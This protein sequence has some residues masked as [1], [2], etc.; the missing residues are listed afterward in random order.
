VAIDGKGSL[1]DQIKQALF[2]RLLPVYCDDFS[3]VE[4]HTSGRAVNWARLPKN[5]PDKD[6]YLK[7][8]QVECT[9]LEGITYQCVSSGNKGRIELRRDAPDGP[10]MHAI[11]LVKSEEG[12]P[13]NVWDTTASIEGKHNLYVHLINTNAAQ[14]DPEGIIDLREIRLHYKDAH[15]EPVPLKQKREALLA[16]REEAVRTPVMKERTPSNRRTTHVFER[17]NWLAPTE[18]VK[19]RVPEVLGSLKAEGN[20]N[21]QTITT[22]LVSPENPLTARVITNRFWEQL[23]GR[24]I[25]YTMEDFGT[26][27]M[28]PSHPQL[29]DWLAVY[30][31][32]DLQWDMKAL[33]KTIV[34]S[35]TY[36]QGSTINPEGIQHDPENI[37]LSR[38]PRIRLSAEQLRDQ[39]LAVSGLLS[40]KMFGPPVMPPQPEG[41]WQVV[42][43]GEAWKTSEGEDKFRRGIYTHWRRTSP[44]PSMTTFDSPSREFC[45]PRRIPTNT[46]LQ[47][48]V[49]LNDPVFVEAAKALASRMK[50]IHEND[51]RAQIVTGYQIAL[52][53]SPS[54]NTI[55]VLTNLYREAM[56]QIDDTEQE[57]GV[58]PP[59]V[60]NN[61]EYQ[62]TNEASMDGLT[63]V[64]NAI[65]NLDRFIMKE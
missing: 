17:G 56:D 65:L 12:K 48:L 29:L 35:S 42:Y 9:D 28:K 54:E 18:E 55:D 34:M 53:Q 44:Y 19:A 32:D 40:K 3:D 1:T 20:N 22:W 16:I 45:M 8:T 26:Q 13:M 6:F 39:A 27:G 21:R 23:F 30:F 25:V 41:I 4:I 59:T 2:P 51:I 10:L 43:S 63:V 47:A 57:D 50:K 58:S 52:M 7:Y 62:K 31:R 49:T 37:Y 11:D 33:L 15:P 24:G 14:S 38:G 5:I 46:P 36:R 64:A 60:A 61:G